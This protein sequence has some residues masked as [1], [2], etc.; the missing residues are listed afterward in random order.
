MSMPWSKLR[1]VSEMEVMSVLF[2]LHQLCKFGSVLIM[3]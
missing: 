1:A 3:S 2:F